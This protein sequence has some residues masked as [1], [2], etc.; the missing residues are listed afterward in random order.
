MPYTYI[1]GWPSLNKW[2]YGVRYAKN[3]QLDDLWK[4]YW[5]SSRH[6]S[7]FRLLH[8]D[9]TVIEIRKVFNDSDSARLWEN[10]VLRRCKVVN[11]DK[12]LNKTDNYSIAPMLGD[13]NP[14][15]RD[16]VRKLISERTPKK[17]G[18]DN[19]MS[20]VATREKV[21]LKLKGRRN[22]WQDGDLNP[23]KRPE[24]RCK[25]SKPGNLNPFYNHTH[26]EKTR[27]AVGDR[28]RGVEKEKVTCPHCNKIGGKNTMGRWHFDNCKVKEKL[29][30]KS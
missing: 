6:V 27:K 12:W 17:F 14:S 29:E 1:I 18:K 3:C 10:K 22:Y 26:S 24:V 25:L 11:S 23:S 4:S 7:A 19:P 16:D 5:T 30:G 15:K 21:S 9:P 28:W 8:G 13:A 20:N 2:Y